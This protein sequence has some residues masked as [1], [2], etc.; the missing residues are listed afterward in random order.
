MLVSLPDGIGTGAGWATGAVSG[1]GGG[2]WVLPEQ[3]QAPAPKRAVG[4]GVVEE[5]NRMQRSC[6]RGLDRHC[7]HP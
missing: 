6:H 2:K 4:E 1:G 5:G 7:I 3:V